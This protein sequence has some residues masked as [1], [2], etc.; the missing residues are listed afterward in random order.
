MK[1]HNISHKK[2]CS[3]SKNQTLPST[4]YK[5]KA[6]ILK[7]IFIQKSNVVSGS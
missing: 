3:R 7:E 5:Q 6:Y 1:N 2:C 4:D